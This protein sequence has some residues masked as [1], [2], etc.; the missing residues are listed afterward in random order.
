M[1][2]IN[3]RQYAALH[4]NH[5][6]FSYLWGPASVVSFPYN[7]VNIGPPHWK[8]GSDYEGEQIS[9]IFPLRHDTR[10]WRF[11]CCH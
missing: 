5:F 9:G 10:A 4:K 7:G 3:A 2:N 11:F 6:Y 1:G 8:Q